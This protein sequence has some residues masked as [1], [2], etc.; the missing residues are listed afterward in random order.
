VEKIKDKRQK[1]RKTGNPLS[2]SEHRA[3]IETGTGI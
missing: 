3:K 2:P 1:K